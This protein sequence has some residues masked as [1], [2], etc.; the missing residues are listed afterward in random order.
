M[1]VLVQLCGNDDKHSDKCPEIE[2]T[3][4]VLARYFD[5]DVYT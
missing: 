2:V 3:G 4:R 5:A 1:R